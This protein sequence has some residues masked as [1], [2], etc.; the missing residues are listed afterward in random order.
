MTKRIKPRPRCAW[1]YREGFYLERRTA[2]LTQHEAA[3]YLGVSVRTLRNWELGKYSIPYPAFKLLRM[4]AGGI[5]HA[6]G[7]DG[8]RFGP[9]GALFSPDGRS[10]KSWELD[11]IKLVFSMARQFRSL[12]E[13]KAEAAAGPSALAGARA[14]LPRQPFVRALRLLAVAS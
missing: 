7:W 4:R 8:W 10:F 2:G 1:V 6:Q 14:P 12:M 3:A 9:G 13:R 5:V 11:Q